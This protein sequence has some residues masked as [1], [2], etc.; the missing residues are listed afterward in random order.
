MQMLPKAM[1]LGIVVENWCTYIYWTALDSGQSTGPAIDCRTMDL[2]YRGFL[3]RHHRCY[4]NLVHDAIQRNVVSVYGRHCPTSIDHLID[5]LFPNG[6]TWFA[7]NSYL[8][9]TENAALHS[10]ICTS[11]CLFIV[12]IYSLVSL[13]LLGFYSHLKRNKMWRKNG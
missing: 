8:D 10:R 1:H 4:C 5:Q 6:L 9:T 13:S 7:I 2:L 3:V 11:P 12:L